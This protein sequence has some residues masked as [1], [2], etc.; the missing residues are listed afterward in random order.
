MYIMTTDCPLS[1]YRDQTGYIVGFMIDLVYAVCN[2][3]GIICDTLWDKSQ[4]CWD[5]TLG[6]HSV[7]GQG[8][9]GEIVGGSWVCCIWAVGSG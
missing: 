2:H 8:E 4:N 5:S 9:C 7:A 6:E 1:V 3:T